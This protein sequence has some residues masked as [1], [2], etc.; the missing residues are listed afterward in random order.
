V[1]TTDGGT[2]WV[3][4]PFPSDLVE[5]ADGVACSSTSVCEVVGLG[6]SGVGLALRTTDGGTTWVSQEVPADT[7][8]LEE[9]ACPSSTAC[10]AIGYNG[11][12]D[13]Q[14]ALGTANGGTSWVSEALPAGETEEGGRL[15][16]LACPSASFCMAVGDTAI[17]P[18]VLRLT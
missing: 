14:I 1:R 2:K 18:I 6:F 3:S 11:L 13:A 15:T 9:I 4:E 8:T 10:E 12:S 7:G 16:G 5:Y 17:D